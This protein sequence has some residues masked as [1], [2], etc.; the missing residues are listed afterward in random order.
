M[1]CDVCGREMGRLPSAEPHQEWACGWCHARATVWAGPGDVTRPQY[2]PVDRRWERA[3][4][5]ADGLVHGHGY[6][7]ATLC[8]RH[9]RVTASPYPWVPGRDDACPDC[10]AAAAVIDE[11]WPA[12]KRNGNRERLPLSPGSDAPPF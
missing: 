12:A 9:Q 4:G 8:G 3:D 6:F 2:E 5:T 7:G 10:R 11:R 1:R